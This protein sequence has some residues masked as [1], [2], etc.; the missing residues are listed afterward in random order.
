MDLVS[1]SASSLEE[2]CGSDF[3][4]LS[5]CEE[6][7]EGPQRPPVSYWGDAWRRFKGNPV[8]V[9]SLAALVFFL[10][11]VV[12]G[13]SIGGFD[14]YA[15]DSSALN[16][17][18]DAIHWFGTDA[19]GRDLFARVWAGARVSLVVALA[20]TA[21]QMVVGSLCGAAMAYFGGI[22]D[23][24]LMRVIEIVS[25]VPDLLVMLLVMMVAGNDM[26]ALLLAMCVTS[27]MDTSRQVRGVIKQLRESEYVAAAECL[28]VSPWKIIARHLLP[29]TISIILLDL[30]MSIPG[31]IFSEASLS[32]LG[33]GLKAP[34]ISLG[35]LVSDGQAVIEIFPHELFFPALVLCLIV[36]AFN[37]FGD[38][39]RDALDPKMRK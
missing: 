20:C 3:K 39:L 38:C 35:T 7:L 8:A 10:V 29:N 37:L 15:T 11:M 4:R 25:S 26:G 2:V 9:V 6:C 21:V 34:A 30:F 36:L 5:S 28:G 24:S 27:W 33:M 12:I 22:V 13:P 14:L 1:S 18:P 32:F 16:A 31:Y 19:L 17:E 23:E